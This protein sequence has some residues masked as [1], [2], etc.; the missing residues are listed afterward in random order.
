[1]ECQQRDTGKIK[2]LYY[3][4][5]TL[6][7]PVPLSLGGKFATPNNNRATG[8]VAAVVAACVGE[9]GYF[10]KAVVRSAMRDAGKN[11]KIIL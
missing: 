10:F 3:N 9:H 6:S 11:N 7:P 2:K 5:I 4:N 1:V 8:C